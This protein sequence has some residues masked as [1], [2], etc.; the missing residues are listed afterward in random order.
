MRIA[1][2]GQRGIPATWGGVE[3]H[4]E[5]LATRLVHEGHEV[6]VYTRPNYTDS[7]LRE[8]KGV[9][10]VALPTLGTKHFDAIVHCL[11]STLHA[12]AGDY[13]L[14]HYHAIGP[15]L[16]AP[17]ARLRG[18]RVVATVHG[19][20]WQRGKWGKFASMVLRAGEW[21]ALHVTHATISVSETLAD[22]YRKG[23]KSPERI[24]FIPNGVSLPE[25]QD[26][27]ILDDLGIDG[28]PYILF[29][30]RIVPEKGVHYLIDAWKRLGKPLKL[31]IAGDTSYSD[32]YV[33][34]VKKAEA[35]GVIFPGYVYGERLAALFGRA[36]LFVLPSDL[37]GY[38]IVLLEALAL[39]A[40][41]LASDIPQNVEAIG[42]HGRFF[43]ASDVDS[44]T[45]E[46]ERAITDLADLKEAAEAYRGEA[47]D[48]FDWDHVTERTLGVYETVVSR[49]A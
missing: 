7:S 43:A 14:V 6:T 23:V 49:R 22:R 37:E 28:E 5:E 30:S 48:K 40:P 31:V 4:V 15:T 24:H 38:P 32:D 34:R 46:L 25:G 17:L 41:V 21:N 3:R 29:A 8:Y 45:T 18:Y 13:D 42:E 1:M 27:R 11:L 47:L 35:D 2:I 10:L 26:T 16:V 36:S 20:D 44:L 33:A 19:Q 9:R 39:G 12:W